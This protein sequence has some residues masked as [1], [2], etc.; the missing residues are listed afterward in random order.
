MLKVF[1]MMTPNPVT[2]SEDAPLKTVWNLMKQEGHP[3]LPV[4]NAQGELTGIITDR[5]LRLAINS[6]YVLHERQDD[7]RLLE[8]LTALGMMSS[9]PVTVTPD[10]PACKA[11]EI[12]GERK[13]GALP[14]TE[15]NYVVGIIS[16]TDFLAQFIAE[17]CRELG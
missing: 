16:V 1:D 17:R 14:V 12:L 15:G 13:F 5:D 6:P 4:V 11:A 7:E 10:A 8:T 2:V 9:N 3:Q